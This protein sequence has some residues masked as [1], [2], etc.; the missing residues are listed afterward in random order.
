VATVVLSF[1]IPQVFIEILSVI[2]SFDRP[3]RM[4]CTNCCQIIKSSSLNI[5][6]THTFWKLFRSVL[7]IFAHC[8][9]VCI[10]F[11][12][13]CVCVF[14]S[15]SQEYFGVFGNMLGVHF[16][17]LPGAFDGV[18]HIQCDLLDCGVFYVSHHFPLPALIIFGWTHV[19]NCESYTQFSG[20]S[21]LR[22]IF[23]CVRTVVKDLWRGVWNFVRAKFD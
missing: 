20:I 16:Q 22:E 21:K 1:F 14:A 9:C 23:S 4:K 19:S 11:L 10:L 5:C 6:L 3:S 12:L 2:S 7:I 17:L 8:V 18:N 13:L 15:S